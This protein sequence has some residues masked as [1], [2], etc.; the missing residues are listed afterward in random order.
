MKA[1][2]ENHIRHC[3]HCQKAKFEAQPGYGFSHLRYYAGPA[4]CIAIDIV[5]LNGYMRRSA[6]TQILTLDLHLRRSKGRIFPSALNTPP[7][8]K[9]SRWRANGR[10]IGAIQSGFCFAGA[11][12]LKVFFSGSASCLP[13]VARS[14]LAVSSSLCLCVV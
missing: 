1:D 3:I 7:P 4:Q 2:I 9:H 5:V 6:F 10:P 11:L 8:I 12:R 14:V 13:C